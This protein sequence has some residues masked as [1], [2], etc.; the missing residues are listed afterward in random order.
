MR[1]FDA[2]LT[3]ADIMTE[4]E[5]EVVAEEP[6]TVRAISWYPEREPGTIIRVVMDR[7]RDRARTAIN[8]LDRFRASRE[9]SPPPDDG[10]HPQLVERQA[11]HGPSMNALPDV[12]VIFR[13]PGDRRAYP[14][15]VAEIQGDRAYL[16]PILRPCIGW[17]SIEHFQT[18]ISENLSEK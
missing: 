7:H 5:V 10:R 6:A 11:T 2:F 16:P 13:P 14:C 9:M 15:R 3:T 4:E 17:V 1:V 8:V 18:P 12:A